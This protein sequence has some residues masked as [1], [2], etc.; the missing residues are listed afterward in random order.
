MPPWASRHQSL[1]WDNAEDR[2]PSF[3]NTKCQRGKKETK[4]DPGNHKRWKRHVNQL[5]GWE[6]VRIPFKQTNDK[7]NSMTTAN[8]WTLAGYR[9]FI[10]ICSSFYWEA[11]MVQGLCLKGGPLPFSVYRWNEIS[12]RFNSKESL[13]GGTVSRNRD[14]SGVE[15]YRNKRW[16]AGLHD[17]SICLKFCTWN[18]R[19]K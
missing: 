13:V 15:N 6:L 3:F 9:V 10:R 17:I 14:W 19:T 7:W 11:A 1:L 5:L 12:L 16:H 4:E 2:A 18:I 8:M